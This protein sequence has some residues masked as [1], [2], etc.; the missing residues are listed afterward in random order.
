M[1]LFFFSSFPRVW[2]W[3]RQSWRT[4]LEAWWWAGWVIHSLIINANCVQRVRSR[5]LGGAGLHGHDV[6]FVER[7]MSENEEEV[8]HWNQVRTN[9]IATFGLMQ[10]FLCWIRE[11]LFMSIPFSLVCNSAWIHFSYIFPHPWSRLLTSRID[12]LLFYPEA[13]TCCFFVISSSNYLRI[14]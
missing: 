6:R 5:L 7:K 14:Q 8:T 11:G 4:F 13:S 9:V 12:L 3:C 2:L 10:L 1:K